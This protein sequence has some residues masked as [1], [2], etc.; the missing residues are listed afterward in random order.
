MVLVDAELFKAKV[1]LLWVKVPELVKLP[2]IVVVAEGA[3][4]VPLVVKFPVMERM[5]LVLEALKV[6]LL[7]KLPVMLVPAE[8]AALKVAEEP[9]VIL[10]ATVKPVLLA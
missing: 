10:P 1:P 5:E 3:I 7:V 9:T 4:N 6:P 8:L 2:L